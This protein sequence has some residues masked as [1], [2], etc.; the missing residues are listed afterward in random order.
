MNPP[1]LADLVARTRLRDGAGVTV[2]LELPPALAAVP[3]G[4][5]SPPLLDLEES[6]RARAGRRAYAPEPLPLSDLAAILAA[7]RAGA[8]LLPADAVELVT[9]VLAGDVEGCPRALYRAGAAELEQVA[10]LPVGSR[11]EEAVLQSEFARTPAILLFTGALAGATARWGAHGHRLL[12]FRAGLAAHA[13]WV[14]AEARELAGCAFSGLLPGF[15]REIGLADG[16]RL[17][18]VF[19]FAV[20]PRADQ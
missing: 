17:A 9:F 7:A 13:A 1:P 12:H 10:E 18:P 19:A 16:F 4:A 15:L 6:L 5:P 14:A 2:P 20:G 11:V 8:G 3:L